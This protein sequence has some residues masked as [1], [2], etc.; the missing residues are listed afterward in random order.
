MYPGMLAA[1]LKVYGVSKAAAVSE[2]ENCGRA[3]LLSRAQLQT[4]GQRTNSTQLGA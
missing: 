4:F 3:Q 2:A 1:Q